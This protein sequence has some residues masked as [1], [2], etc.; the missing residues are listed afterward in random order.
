MTN[1]TVWKYPL[2]LGRTGH[3]LPRNA[4]LLH[5]ADQAGTI[6][7]WAKGDPSAEKVLREFVVHGTGHLFSDIGLSHVGTVLVLGGRF[8]WHV[9]EVNAPHK[10]VNC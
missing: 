9:F 4:E 6:C 1:S 10:V 5:V 2:C 3:E 7:L 8:V